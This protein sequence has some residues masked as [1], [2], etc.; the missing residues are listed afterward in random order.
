MKHLTIFAAFAVPALAGPFAPAAG[1]MGST[2]IVADDPAIIAWADSVTVQ[3]GPTDIASDSA[4]DASFGSPADAIG[5]ADAQTFDATPVVSLGD[6]GAATATFA[7]PIVDGPGADFA[8][9]ENGFNDE[10]L[11]LAFVEVSSNGEQ[12]VRFPSQSLTPTDTQVNQV[13]GVLID[14]TDIDGLA[15]KY[16]A[17]YGT[18]FDLADLRALDLPPS[19]DLDRI[20][21]VRVVDV[22]GTIDPA[23]ASRDSSGSII[24]DP[25]T[26]DFTSGGF[27]LDAI[28]VLHADPTSYA[29]WEQLYFG[30]LAAKNADPDGD[31]VPNEIEYLTGGNPLLRDAAIYLSSDR[32]FTVSRDFTRA[33]SNLTLET[34]DDLSSWQALGTFDD[35]ADAFVPTDENPTSFSQS[36]H[37]FQ[38]PASDDRI[39]FFRLTI[40]P[41]SP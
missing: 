40:R 3:R 24:N 26:T 9:F 34:T 19:L 27:D 10:F 11:E 18:P 41:P 23:Y 13:A 14:T 39:R 29:E 12:F 17:F 28:G 4:L 37:Q 7:R 33:G 30:R 21:H 38:F 32:S 20:T 35:A 22:V 8:V 6:G 31:G 25:Y 36:G 1:E 5:P 16:R 15:G 2:A